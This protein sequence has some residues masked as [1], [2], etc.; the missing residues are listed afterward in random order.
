[1]VEQTA[2]RVKVKLWLKAWQNQTDG[3]RVH[4]AAGSQDQGGDRGLADQDD[5]RMR[6]M[7]KP[8]ERRSLVEPKGWRV[9]P[10]QETWKSVAEAKR[11]LTEAG[12]EGRGS[13]EES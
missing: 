4:G 10:Q 9:E 6:M 11:R 7:G 2:G 13:P 5:G 3:T 1:M 8:E 12:P